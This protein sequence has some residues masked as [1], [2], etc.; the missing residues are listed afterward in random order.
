MK[1][2]QRRPVAQKEELGEQANCSWRE[3]PE[4]FLPLLL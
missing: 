3:A 1:E 4:G 2:D